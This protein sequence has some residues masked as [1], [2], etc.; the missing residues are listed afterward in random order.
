VTASGRRLAGLEYAMRLT[1]DVTP[2]NVVAV[3]Q[4]AGELPVA[5][6]RTALDEWQRRH[7][8]LR[9]RIVP[10]GKNY[11]FHF[12]VT[13]PIPLDVSPPSGADGWIA[14]AQDAL[15]TRFELA[16][17][18]LVRC[19]YLPRESGADLIITVHHTIIDAASATHV[20][21]E[22][23]A[24]CAGSP[25]ASPAGTAPE[26]QQPAAALFPRE[27][28][29][30]RFVRAAAA[31][32]G[33]Q[34]AD[35]V[36]FQWR[37]RGVRKPPIAAT[38]RCCILPIRF[39]PAL[40]ASLILASRRQ[41][42]TLNAILSAGLMAAVQRR[43]Y[44]SKRAPLR[45]IIFADLR[46]RLRTPVPDSVLGCLLTMFR[47]TVNVERDGGFWS[48]ARDIQQSTQRAAQSGERYLSY[49]MSPGMMKMI[50]GT[51]AF[52]M[53]ATALSYSGPT[54]LPVEY[55]SFQVTGLHA[56][57]ANMTLGPEYSALVRLFRGELWWDILYLDSDMDAA[58]AQA[59]AREMQEIL[60]RATC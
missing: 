50:L 30:V 49:A 47:F 23:L 31:F 4:I 44:P 58:G 5:T 8:L 48:L 18:P 25:P 32:M 54:T 46:P 36:T 33:R 1:D 22:L 12:D 27:F 52:R 10:S 13:G 53:G 43:L 40:T 56:F 17:G 6:L 38:G 39:S 9:T 7:P 24:L 2:F 19:R 26:G 57:A 59:I 21:G 60:E 51:K 29:G 34:M 45:H 11:F 55:G 42:V 37:S 16:V 3:L 41:R 14:A 28:T 15:H 35:E 20:F